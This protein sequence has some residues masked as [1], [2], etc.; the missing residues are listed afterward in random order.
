MKNGERHGLRRPDTLQ[1]LLHTLS[2]AA[3]AASAGVLILIANQGGSGASSFLIVGVDTDV[4]ENSPRSVFDID[5]CA[6][7]EVGES[8]DVDVVTPEPGIPS[9]RGLSGYQFRLFYD[10]EIVW[11]TAD[12]QD[13]LLDQAAGSALIPLADPKPDKNGIYLSAAVDFGPT[14]IEPSGASETGPGVLGRLTLEARGPGLTPLVV[15]AVVLKDDDSDDIEVDSVQSGRLY[16]GE[17]CPGF[18]PP[19]ATTTPSATPAPAPAATDGGADDGSTAPPSEPAALQE[20]GGGPLP[21]DDGRA[22]RLVMFGGVLAAI[23]GVIAWRV[24]ALESG[25][26][27]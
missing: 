20:A 8:I 23:G 21:N 18:E 24:Q 12:D 4:A 27:L 22:W 19:K 1:R 25:A 10:P 26:R 11:V 6:S 3:I 5:D 7:I 14:G 16:V 17:P 15:T 2:A 9:E 13:Q